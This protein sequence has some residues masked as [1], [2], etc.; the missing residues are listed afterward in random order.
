[1]VG[2]RAES[3]R[4]AVLPPDAAIDFLGLAL[5]CVNSMQPASATTAAAAN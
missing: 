3:G 1:V 5:R 2:K 4:A